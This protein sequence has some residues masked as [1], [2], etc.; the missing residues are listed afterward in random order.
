MRALL[1]D[2]YDPTARVII[3]KDKSSCSLIQYAKDNQKN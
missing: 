3:E 1:E 2:G